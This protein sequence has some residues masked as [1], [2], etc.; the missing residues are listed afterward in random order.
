MVCWI[1]RSDVLEILLWNFRVVMLLIFQGSVSVVTLCHISF[2]K[3]FCLTRQLLNTITS[4]FRCQ[5]LFYYIFLYLKR[6]INHYLCC[7]IVFAA[8]SFNKL[9]QCFY[10]VNY[11]LDF[12]I[13]YVKAGYLQYGLM[14]RLSVEKKYQRTAV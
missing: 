14:H 3:N 9:S 11:F 8:D 6:K 12:C 1:S 13:L 7:I 5:H 10:N 2:Q 4:K